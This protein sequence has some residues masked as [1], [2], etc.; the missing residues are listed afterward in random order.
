MADKEN[1]EMKPQKLT[2]KDL[3]ELDDSEFATTD[4][5]YCR[6]FTKDSYGYW[7][8]IGCYSDVYSENDC[9]YRAPR[10]GAYSWT[11]NSC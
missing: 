8:Q 7:Q 11:R 1:T 4:K 6:V 3:P 5:F 2:Q 10:E 9:T